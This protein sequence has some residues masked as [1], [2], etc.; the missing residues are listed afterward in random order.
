MKSEQELAEFYQRLKKELE[1][2]TSFPTMYLY[3]F[4][5]PTDAQKLETLNSIFK[6]TNAEIKTRPSSNG[7]YTGVSV[8]VL[9]QNPDEV[10]HYYREAGKIEGIVSL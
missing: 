7:K 10:I 1:E 8:S 9:L 2:T 5:I 3:K 4:I 6:Q